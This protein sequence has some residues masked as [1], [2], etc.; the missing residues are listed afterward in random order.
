MLTIEVM[1]SEVL[2]L[3]EVRGV[4]VST[5]ASLWNSQHMI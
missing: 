4:E 1:K 5:L 3:Q 2:I